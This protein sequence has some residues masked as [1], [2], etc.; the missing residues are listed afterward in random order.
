MKAAPEEIFP[1][2]LVML[3]ATGDLAKRKLIPAL[4]QLYTAGQL[5]PLLQV[6]GFAKDELSDKEFQEMVRGIVEGS[7]KET[8]N[9]KQ[10]EGFCQ[11]FL[12]ETGQFEDMEAYR[13]LGERMGRVD[14]AWR[15]CANK[16]FYI[17]AS[18]VHYQIIFQHLAQSGLTE[19]CSDEEGWTRVIVEKPFGKD[20]ATAQELDLLLGK[21][22]REEQIYRV[23]HYLGKD[24]VRNLLTFRFSNSFLEPAWNAQGIDH[25]HI[26][27]FEKEGVE[28]RGQFY[29]GI[30]ALRDV[31]QNHM[32]QLLALI[33]MDN[34]E[35]FDA[36]S[37][38]RER[39]RILEML[40]AMDPQDATQQT[41]RAQYE[42]YQN[43]SGVD[44]NSETETY[45]NIKTYLKSPRW[46]GVPIWL[47][48]GKRMPEAQASVEVHFRHRTP[49][50]C[51]PGKH[52]TNVLTYR[53]QPHEGIT[54]TFWV[55]RPGSEMVI[56]KQD[57]E[58]D[59]E[60]AYEGEFMDAYTKLLLDMFR[61]DQTLFV[62]TDEIMA[63]WKFVDPILQAWKKNVVVMETYKPGKKPHFQSSPSAVPGGALKQVGYIGLG[64]MGLN[65]V[66]RML[67][68]KW[69]VV[70]TD[71]S[72]EAR[73][74]AEKAGAKTV[75]SA[76]EVV[77]TLRP[78]K[79]SSRGRQAQENIL[80]WLMVPH[81]VVDS[82]LKEITPHLEKGDTV[83]DGGNS[84]YKDSVRR[85]EEL[86]K[87][88]IEFL[89]IGVSGGP[90]GAR[91]GACLMIGGKREVYKKYVGLF[92]DLVTAGGY[93][94]V[95]TAGAG[96]FVKMVHNGIE[97]GM[98]QAIGEGFAVMK[99]KKEFE[100]NLEAIANVYNHGSVIE[101]RLIGWLKRAYDQYGPDLV[102]ISGSVEHSGEGLWTVEAAKEL[103]IPVN[104][105]EDALQFRIE[106][107]QKPSYIGQVVSALRNQFGGHNV[108]T[109]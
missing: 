64:K 81:T 44:K 20:L 79:A 45:F 107:H 22:F 16:L 49:C 24:T 38:R 13:R 59:Y 10:L 91:S 9:S 21:L 85:A 63:E 108:K 52:Y 94:Y 36:D 55:K 109:K 33:T 71:P 11:R 105:I 4:W 7:T 51:P 54:T 66:Q 60:K 67:D 39:A 89:D 32:L 14:N 3:G 87:S 68:Y 56:E 35:S 23:D 77:R 48:S 1:T 78:R 19:P 28:E 69:D 88:G 93:E 41:V 6:M 34:P 53:V 17:A 72:E 40:E 101:S 73:D 75:E 15:L 104:V 102:G 18:P 90:E 98:M 96:H 8:V 29:D 5:S 12:Y 82:V 86:A 80:I 92:S 47:E 57:F 83:I 25:I 2:V 27:V 100:L 43:I 103:G 106:S 84:N 26:R 37:I 95:G 61:G 50:L 70:A 42:E 30:G 65:M 31:G 62:S 99:E 46:S 58:F 74:K 97:Y 76:A